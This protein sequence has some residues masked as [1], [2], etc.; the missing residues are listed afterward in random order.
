V[1]NI[2]SDIVLTS[3]EDIFMQPGI[4]DNGGNDKVTE[5]VL[6]ELH[7]FKS[8]PFKVLD[9]D[10]M[11]ETADSVKQYGILVPGLVRPREEGGY[12]IV[13]GHRR[14]RACEL[15]GLDTM[16][17]IIR[18]LDDD[19]AAIVCVD[20]N[21]HREEILP[22][23]KA[24]AYKLKLDA[25]RRKAGRRRKNSEPVVLNFED[26]QSREVL[27]KISGDSGMQVSRYI[28][29]TELVPEL[30]S[31]VDEKQ[32]AFNPAVE[33]SY[34]NKEEQQILLDVIGL[35]ES[36]P[37]LSQAQRLKKLSQKDG[38]SFELIESI[39][40]EVKKDADKIVIKGDRLKKYFPS[41]F[42]P[43]QMEETIIELLE[44]WVKDKKP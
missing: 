29:L 18:N 12:E 35:I 14:K 10:K 1:N 24:F 33:L 15:A 43:R 36:V 11:N 2:R 19:E 37:S 9:D 42:T 44:N 13:S 25:M 31:K 20:S 34:L 6:T 39:L 8:H 40:S 23:E 3:Y 32:I 38:L 28:R 26:Q 16:P 17:A 27:G 22:S 30:L 41:T 21:L 7:P 5:I 4:S